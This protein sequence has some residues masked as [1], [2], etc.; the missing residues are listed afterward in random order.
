MSYKGIFH[1][2]NPKKY[3]GNPKRIV[4]RSLWERM[5]M[6]YCDTSKS[7]SEW[8]SE[9]LAI[10]YI[11]P[12]DKK[13]HRYYPD[14]YLKTIEGNKFIIEIKPKRQCIEPKIQKTKNRKYVR[15]VMEYAKNQAKWD[16]Q[17]YGYVKNKAK[18]DSASRFCSKHGLK[19]K[20]LTEDTLGS[21]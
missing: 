21:Y 8:G 17:V 18:W 14:F 20:I 7:I 4:Y 12:L 1:P 15:E 19:F 2:S 13:M 6:V 9:E 10:P 3:V 5:F 11:S 16:K